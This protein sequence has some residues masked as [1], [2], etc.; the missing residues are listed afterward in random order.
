MQTVNFEKIIGNTGA[1]EGGDLDDLLR[2]ARSRLSGELKYERRPEAAA[3][4]VSSPLGDLFVAVTNRGIAM[5]HYLAGAGDIASTIDELRPRLDLAEDRRT[6]D[7]VAAEVRRYLSGEA[8][9]LR[10][11]IDLSLAG[12][13]FQQ[14]VLR[15]LQEVP[16]GAVI[17]YQA[18]GAAAGSPKG[19]RAVGNAMHNNPVPIY[20]PCHRVIASGGGL[21]G[22]GGGA[23][24]KLQLLRS[25][26]FDLGDNAAKLPGNALWGHQRTKIYCRA[27]CRTVARV[28]QNRILFFADAKDARHAGLRPCKVCRPDRERL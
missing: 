18:L 9:A 2:H 10:Q 3:G 14:K 21:G 11:D 1:L 16:R 15:K 4:V 28:D 27:D 19:A 8:S 23:G 22:Y 6:T 13:S 26:G 5:I 12:S 20:V 25:E 24:R 17:S 7:G